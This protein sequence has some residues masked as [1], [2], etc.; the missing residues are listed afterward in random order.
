[1]KNVTILVMAL[2][3]ACGS[4]VQAEFLELEAT[5]IVTIEPADKSAGPRLLV[6]WELPKD[7]GEKIIDG[8]VVELS[9][10]HEA[11]APFRVDVHPVTTDWDVETVAWSDG[12]TNAG[13]DFADSIVAP[14]LVTER[15]E[16]KIT[17]DVYQTV[18]DQIA[19]KVSNFGFIVVPEVTTEAQLTSATAND[20]KLKAAARLIIAYRKQR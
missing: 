9:V 6:R 12:W 19:G 3:L 11:T 7:L 13:G 15:N 18:L 17:G 14:A 20:A 5:S 1:M 4:A 16:G 2:V 8:A 10:P